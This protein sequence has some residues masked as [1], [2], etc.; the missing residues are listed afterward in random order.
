MDL[1]GGGNINQI[2]NQLSNLMDQTS[3]NMSRKMSDIVSEMKSQGGTLN[4][5]QTNQLQVLMQTYMAVVTT[6]SS[7]TKQVGDLNKSIAQ[8]IGT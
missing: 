6:F 4:P 2:F 1:S 8:N 5:V 7:I 3:D